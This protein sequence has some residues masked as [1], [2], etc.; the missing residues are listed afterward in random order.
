M[1]DDRVQRASESGAGS[2]DTTWYSDEDQL[3]GMVRQDRARVTPPSIPGYEGLHELRRGG[4]GVVYVGTQA[5]TKQKV[6]IK[7]L[8]AGSLASPAQRRRFEREAEL[9]ASLRHPNIVRVF[10]SGTTGEGWPYIVMEFVEG[11]SLDETIRVATITRSRLPDEPAPGPE[12]IVRERAELLAKIASAVAHA[13]VRGVLHRDLKPGNI[14]VDAAGEPRVLDFGLAKAL[15]TGPDSLE[16]SHTGQFLGSLP[17]ASPEQAGEGAVD[18]RTDVYALGVIAYQLLTGS[19]PYDTSGGVARALDAIRSAIPAPPRS[20]NPAID[21]DLQAI[22]LACLAKDPSRRYQSAID[23]HADLASWLEGEPIRARRESGW[24]AL[25]RAARRYRRA[26]WATGLVAV[27]LAAAAGVTAYQAREISRQRDQV[28]AQRARAEAVSTFL[29]KMLAAPHPERDGRDVKVAEVLDEAARDAAALDDIGARADIRLTLGQSYSALGLYDL[30][31]DQLQPALADATTRYGE[32]SDQALRT[33]EELGIARYYQGRHGEAIEIMERVVDARRATSGPGHVPTLHALQTLA[34][35]LKETPRLGEALEIER[36]VARELAALRGPTHPD[37]IRARVNLANTMR[38]LDQPGPALKEL[39]EVA[40][41]VARSGLERTGE[42]LSAL[43]NLAL[44]SYAAGKRDRAVEVLERAL[45]IAADL[46]GPDHPETL[47][48]RNNL[49]NA[50]IGT[51]RNDQAEPML[52]EVIESQR[53]AL[54]PRHAHLVPSLNNLATLHK[55]RND[56]GGAEALLREA[57]AIAGERLG[58][59]HQ[60][61]LT[62]V[63]NLGELLGKTGRAP[64]AVA[65]MAPALAR[66]R[67]AYG[68]THSM[69]LLLVHN[70]GSTHME[71]REFELAE[72]LLAESYRGAREASGPTSEDATLGAWQLMKLYQRWERPDLEKQWQDVY[73]RDSGDRRDKHESRRL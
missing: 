31:A 19:Q 9:A 27:G 46:N 59:D 71:A 14:R 25:R 39:E 42:G 51:G 54:G 7:V 52:R 48:V 45:P 21:D 65:L 35:C 40:D 30:A 53:R 23:L 3:L 60:T 72:P 63:S 6:A 68:D 64:E 12:A 29:V 24:D 62:T 28:E 43:A 57:L 15:A 33:L 41:L 17:W 55:R 18:T 73:E 61:T 20:L 36:E 8:L 67:A 2:P 4:Q 56:P 58:P 16:I 22:V 34:S 13:H 66:S 1:L 11:W 5:A 26:A 70:L 49:A 47:K 10:A 32:R 38:I 69:T 37:A 50:L 44:A